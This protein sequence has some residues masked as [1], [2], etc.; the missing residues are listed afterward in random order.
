MVSICQETIFESSE[1]KYSHI[2]ATGGSEK[3]ER[4]GPWNPWFG[5]PVYNLRPQS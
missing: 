2:H 4:T 3:V 1:H 5:S